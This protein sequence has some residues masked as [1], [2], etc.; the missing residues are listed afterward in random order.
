METPLRGMKKHPQMPSGKSRKNP[1][2][3]P[4]N[5]F[6][7]NSADFQGRP[8]MR[9]LRLRKCPARRGFSQ[10]RRI[11]PQTRRSIIMRASPFRRA[12]QNHPENRC[13]RS[14]EEKAHQGGIL[15]LILRKLCMDPK[16]GGFRKDLFGRITRSMLNER[17]FTVVLPHSANPH[18]AVKLIAQSAS[19]PTAV[20]STQ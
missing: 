12:R 17:P 14:L 18:S 10:A 5:R 11:G 1:L 4:I 7:R 13:R 20:S 8:L 15:H 6:L 9:R 19:C 16:N 3:F 2:K